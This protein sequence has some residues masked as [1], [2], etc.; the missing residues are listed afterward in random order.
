MGSGAGK[1]LQQAERQGGEVLKQAR[2]E[3]TPVM[4]A[5]L[6]QSSPGKPRHIRFLAQASDDICR[7]MERMLM[8][9]LA[10]GD[11]EE[12]RDEMA[13][14][15]AKICVDDLMRKAKTIDVLAGRV[16]ELRN[17]RMNRSGDAKEK[18]K[19]LVGEKALQSEARLLGRIVAESQ[20]PEPH[21]VS[22]AERE[23]TGVMAE[24]MA[25]M[26]ENRARSLIDGGES[27]ACSH[28]GY[29]GIHGYAQGAGRGTTGSLNLDSPS[30]P[31]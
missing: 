30:T 7:K 19:A 25:V 27:G 26:L 14:M 5:F 1:A 13:E 12:L 16:N 11:H 20:T 18:M 24:R 4:D 31:S 6:E 28:A 23:I 3:A 15:R 2:R 10:P 21:V 8:E 22:I 29:T 9:K 17:G